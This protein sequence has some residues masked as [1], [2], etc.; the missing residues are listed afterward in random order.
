MPCSKTMRCSG[1]ATSFKVLALAGVENPKGHIGRH[2][3]SFLAL[4]TRKESV[5][6]T[7]EGGCATQLWW[8]TARRSCGQPLSEQSQNR[9][10]WE[11]G[12]CH[13]TLVVVSKT[14]PRA[15]V[16]HNCGGVGKNAARK[17]L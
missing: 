15:A 11:P 7:A 17:R 2:H 14:Q 1:L 9:A 10:S 8:W 6:D 4:T 12:L 16:P 13:T 5:Q 3:W